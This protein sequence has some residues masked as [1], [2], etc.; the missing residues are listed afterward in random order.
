VR[1]PQTVFFRYSGYGKRLAWK[2]ADQYIVIWDRP[3]FYGTNVTMW[4]F[5]EVFRVRLTSIFVPIR[6]KHTFPLGALEGQTHPTN[7]AEEV[8]ESKTHV[9]SLPA[10][11][12]TLFSNTY[13][14]PNENR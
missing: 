4:D 6:R 1:S 10:M 5:A 12:K 7:A 9:F 11:S 3:G 8:Y 14:G 13:E 2:A